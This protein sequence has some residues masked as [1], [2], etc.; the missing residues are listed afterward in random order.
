MS[1][2]PNIAFDKGGSFLYTKVATLKGGI[3]GGN[4]LPGG[5]EGGMGGGEAANP[6][7][8]SMT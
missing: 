7:F 5:A 8:P 3:K 4:Q 6:K 2:T 1:K